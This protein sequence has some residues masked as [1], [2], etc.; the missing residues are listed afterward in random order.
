MLDIKNWVERVRRRR[1]VNTPSPSLPPVAPAPRSPPS[2]A[3]AGERAPL[4]APSSSEEAA[5]AAAAQQQ[6]DQ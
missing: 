1:D 6:L 5:K 3:V 2:A 4:L